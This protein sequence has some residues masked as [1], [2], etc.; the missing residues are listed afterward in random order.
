MHLAVRVAVT[1]LA[2]VIVQEGVRLAVRVHAM[3]V[4]P[5]HATMV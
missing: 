4:V 5:V 2:M 3:T 1:V